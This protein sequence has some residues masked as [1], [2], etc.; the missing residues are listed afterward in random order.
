MGRGSQSAFRPRTPGGDKSL[1]RPRS[2]PRTP[3]VPDERALH[4]L[5]MTRKLPRISAPQPR[6]PLGAT[7]QRLGRRL[8]FPPIRPSVSGPAH[9]APVPSHLLVL[10]PHLLPVSEPVRARPLPRRGHRPAELF[11][12]ESS[13]GLHLPPACPLGPQLPLHPSLSPHAPAQPLLLEPACSPPPPSHPRSPTIHDPTERPLQGPCSGSEGADLGV[14]TA[15]LWTRGRR[16]TDTHPRPPL[17]AQQ[18]GPTLHLELASPWDLVWNHRAN[19]WPE[20]EKGEHEEAE[21]LLAGRETTGQGL[22]RRKLG[23]WERCCLETAWDAV[24][25]RRR[26]PGARERGT[27]E[28]R[29]LGARWSNAKAMAGHPRESVTQDEVHQNQILQEL[30]L[31]ELPARNVYARHHVNPSTRSTDHQEAHV[32]AW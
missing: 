30:Y 32:L 22:D 3:T 29:A 20:T 2:S 1:R 23:L 21:P 15:W 10:L 9:Y 27:R 12:R 17:P 16:T 6:R 26:K 28:Q 7:P 31:K 5:K 4:A 13:S 24:A 14:P 11:V 8:F 18:P 25:W 19:C